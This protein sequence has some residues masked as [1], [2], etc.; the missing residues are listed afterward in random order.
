MHLN[1][2]LDQVV[3]F[4]LSEQINAINNQPVHIK[5]RVM[6]INAVQ[7]DLVALPRP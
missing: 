6:V 5:I 7:F 2:R 3:V 1:Q 4:Y